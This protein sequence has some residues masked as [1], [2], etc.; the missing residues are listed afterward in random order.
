MPRSVRF[1]LFW[2]AALLAGPVTPASA[3]WEP[4]RFHSPNKVADLNKTIAGKVLDFTDNHDCDRRLYSPS[5]GTK[6]DLYV[7]LPPGYDG[8]RQFPVMVWLHG[9]GYDEESFLNIAPI[10]DEAIRA[11]TFPPV[12]VAAPDGTISGRPSPFNAGSFYLAG[13]HGDY[14]GWIARDVWGFVKANFCVRPER[15][16]HVIGGGSM[17]GFGAFNLGFKYRQEFGQIVGIMPPINLRYGDCNGKYLTP[18][19][20]NNTTLRETNR[21][22][23]VIGRFYGVLLIRAR[24]MT[25]P[26]IGRH[27]P[28][29]TGFIASE[30]PMEM[31]AAYD[32]RPDE[33][34]MFIGYGTKDEFNISAQVRSFLDTAAKRGIRPTVVVI[35]DGRHNVQ[36]AKEMFPEFSRWMCGQLAP[37]VPPGYEPTAVPDVAPQA[38]VRRRPLLSLLP[39]P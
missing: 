21:R 16:A 36:T 11:G 39:R 17:G 37:Y 6:R 23:E 38:A 4:F 34:G 8:R 5:L 18:Y 25:D 20:P 31:L 1:T 13:R 32:I 26:V 19:D 7:Y 14:E 35:P 22:N 27:H 29:P 10:F 24:R 3:Q 9:L 2:A 33:F 30:N 28:D 15:E 12:V